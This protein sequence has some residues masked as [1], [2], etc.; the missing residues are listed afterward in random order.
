MSGLGT[1]GKVAWR[2]IRERLRSR[3]YLIATGSTILI[4]LGL[5]VVPPLFSSDTQESTIGIVGN[6]N[7]VIVDTAV[8]LGNANDEPG[9]PPSIAIATLDYDDRETAVA[10][11]ETGEIEAVLVDG[12][13]LVV[14]STSGFG[15]SEIAGRLQRAA[16]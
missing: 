6:G 8:D 16:G 2:E 4:V 11:M 9:D 7:Q 13:E 14:E 15:G 5:I 3:A 12:D 10:A 1:L